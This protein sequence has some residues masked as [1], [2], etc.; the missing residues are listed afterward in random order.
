MEFMLNASRLDY[1]MHNKLLVV[2]NAIALIGGRNIG[3]QFFQIDPE[4]QFAD[5]DIFIAGPIARQLSDDFRRVLEQYPVD[6]GRSAF[7]GKG[8][9]YRIE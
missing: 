5:N 7:S 9:P 3:D 1:R 6:P 2:D 8:I 4:S